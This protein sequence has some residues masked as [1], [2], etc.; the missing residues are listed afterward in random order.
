MSDRER[1]TWPRLVDPPENVKQVRQTGG[2]RAVWTRIDMYY[3]SSPGWEQG[4]DWAQ[5]LRWGEVEDV[6]NHQGRESLFDVRA[7]DQTEPHLGHDWQDGVLDEGGQFW[8][9]RGLS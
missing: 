4:V 7:C 6:T 3:W 8:Y 2:S 1:R 5:V 9:C